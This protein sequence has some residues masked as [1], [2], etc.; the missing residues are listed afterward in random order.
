M[1]TVASLRQSVKCESC[2]QWL[3]APERST[4]VNKEQITHLWACPQCGNEFKTSIFL[5][6][7]VP[8]TPEVVDTFLPSLLVA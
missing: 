1:T 3:M 5:T 4:Y 2:G 6:Q 7:E 8:L